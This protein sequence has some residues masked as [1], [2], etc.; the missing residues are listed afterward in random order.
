MD[1][2]KAGEGGGSCVKALKL[3][4]GTVG[5]KGAYCKGWC[6]VSASP[7]TKNSNRVIA[8]SIQLPSSLDCLDH[9]CALLGPHTMCYRICALQMDQT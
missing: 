4:D 6:T 9:A 5:R 1:V 3:C 7:T 8:F 2:W